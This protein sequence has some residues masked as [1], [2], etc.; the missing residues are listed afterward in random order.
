MIKSVVSKKPVQHL[1]T[2]WGLA[3]GDNASSSRLI[4]SCIIIRACVS[5]ASGSYYLIIV[6]YLLR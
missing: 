2:L 4:S 6:I 1:W 3:I 5:S